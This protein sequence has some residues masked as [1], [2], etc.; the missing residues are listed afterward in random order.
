M[1]SPWRTGALLLVWLLICGWLGSGVL[2]VLGLW[3]GG[4][5]IAVVA[6]S[7]LNTPQ[8]A[9][10]R[11]TRHRGAMSSDAAGSRTVA[12]V[13]GTPGSEPTTTPSSD[14]PGRSNDESSATLAKHQQ[15]N[16]V[17]V[18]AAGRPKDVT[19]RRVVSA[20][21]DREADPEVSLQS[22]PLV[23]MS[24]SSVARVLGVDVSTVQD[25]MMSGAL[26]GNELAGTW[27]CNRES[28]TR[29]IDGG[30][31]NPG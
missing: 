19:G 9:E 4:G 22:V 16:A 15:G 23:V 28:L 25:A 12:G 2:N 18:D 10:A 17:E 30:W 20:D 24:A 7:G 5:L 31:S 13:P 26:P 1:W 14:P 29:W 6:Y 11:S 27:I 8:V 3:V 21:P